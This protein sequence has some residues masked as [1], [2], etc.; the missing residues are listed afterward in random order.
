MY[1]ICINIYTYAYIKEYAHIRRARCE[2]GCR[3]LFGVVC[4]LGFFA[5]E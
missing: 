5:K 1:N 2:L 4:L 3:Q